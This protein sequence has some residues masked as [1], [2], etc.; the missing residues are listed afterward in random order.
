MPLALF[1]APAY[2]AL[3]GRPAGPSLM[4]QAVAP[5]VL[6]FI[7]ESV[8]DAAMLMTVAALA[9]FAFSCFVMLRRPDSSGP[10]EDAA[11]NAA[12]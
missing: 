2:G 1:G 10:D 5:L 6:A 8:P 9:L 11:K 7:T 4:M 12:R 3:I